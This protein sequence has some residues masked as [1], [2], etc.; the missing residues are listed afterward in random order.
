MVSPAPAR[1][2][3]AV[4]RTAGESLGHP[5]AAVAAAAVEVALAVGRR[6]APTGSASLTG[7]AELGAGEN[8]DHW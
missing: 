7:G 8:A 6:E 1:M 5:G 4:A 2:T 3:R